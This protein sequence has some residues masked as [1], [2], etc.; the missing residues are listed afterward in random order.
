M[1]P[2]LS[3]YVGATD[4][5]NSVLWKE[6]K[7]SVR[8]GIGVA[9]TVVLDVTGVSELAPDPLDRFTL[10]LPTGEKFVLIPE[11]TPEVGV[12]AIGIYAEDPIVTY[13]YAC[14]DP[15]TALDRLPLPKKGYIESTAGEILIDLIGL[16]DPTLTTTGIED[17]NL[18][19][20]L[21]LTKLNK[22][23]DVVATE[24]L[25]TGNYIV[26]LGAVTG[27][28]VLADYKENFGAS[29]VEVDYTN[30]F[31]AYEPRTTPATDVPFTPTKEP[32]T[33]DNEIINYQ[34]VKGNSDGGPHHSVCEFRELDV[35]VSSF[36][37]AAKPFG[38]DNSQ[39]FSKQFD[40]G[41]VDVDAN[42]DED[43]PEVVPLRFPATVEIADISIDPLTTGEVCAFT[44]KNGVHLLSAVIG[45]TTIGAKVSGTTHN[46]SIPLAPGGAAADDDH[47]YYYDW[48]AQYKLD[49]TLVVTLY[50]YYL[51]A[52]AG[53][54][55]LATVT[56]VNPTTKQIT[57]SYAAGITADD[58]PE[59]VRFF[60]TGDPDDLQFFAKVTA[61]SGTTITL[62]DVPD[63]DSTIDLTTCDL[64]PGEIAKVTTT[65]TTVYS[66]AAHAN[67]FG[68][69]IPQI[70]GSATAARWRHSFGPNVE[71]ILVD[72]AL[73]GVEGRRLRVDAGEASR[74][75]DLVVSASGDTGTCTFTTTFPILQ[76]PVK[77]LLNYDAAKQP[78]AIVQ[79]AASQAIY[80]IRKGDDIESELAYTVDDCEAIG[81]AVVDEFG[82]PSPQGSITRESTLMGSFPLPPRTVAVNL[83]PEYQI[84]TEAVPISEV[85]VDFGG[86]DPMDE[87]GVVIY[88][89][90]LGK[91][92]SVAVVEREL[93]ALKNSRAGGFFIG[94]S[95]GPRAT[96]FTWDDVS[97]CSIAYTG[98][99]SLTL[100]GKPAATT[101]D[102]RDYTTGNLKRKPVKIMG[103]I[104]GLHVVQVEVIYPPDPV[105]D[106]KYTTRYNAKSNTV[107]YRWGRPA[108]ALTYIVQTLKE[109]ADPGDPDDFNPEERIGAETFIVNYDPTAKKIKVTSVGLAFKES[110]PVDLEI[111]LPPLDAPDL[112]EVV[113]IKPNDRVVIRISARPNARATKVRVFTRQDAG[114]VLDPGVDPALWDDFFPKDNDT[115]ELYE[116]D[117]TDEIHR[118]V[119][120]FE[121]TAADDVVWLS[122]TW[123]DIF[124]QEHAYYEP[125]DA[126][127][128][129]MTI[130]SIDAAT[131]FRSPNAGTPATNQAA[132]GTTE[133]DDDETARTEFSGI[134]RYNLGRH[135][136]KIHL[137]IEESTG[138]ADHTEGTWNDHRIFHTPY[139]VTHADA[140]NGYCDIPV[141]QKFKYSKDKRRT[142]RPHRI[143]ID[144]PKIV[145]R[146]G[147]G[148][149]E[150]RVKQKLWY[151]GHDGGSPPALD[152]GTID[153]V[154]DKSLFEFKPGIA[155][156]SN[157]LPVVTGLVVRSK[158]NGFKAKWSP[159][160][161]TK[162]RRYFI[163]LS[164]SP[165]NTTFN[166]TLATEFNAI[167]GTAD[168]LLYRTQGPS[169]IKDVQAHVLDAGHVDHYR[170]HNL[171]QVGSHSIF[172]DER[173]YVAVIV[174]SKSGRYATAFSSVVDS[175]SGVSVSDAPLYAPSNP[176]TAAGTYLIE[177]DVLTTTS[178]ADARVAVRIDANV[179]ATKTFEEA[180][181]TH[182][183]ACFRP[184]G[185][186]DD[187]RLI[188]VG[189]PVTDRTQLY[190]IVS[191]VFPLGERLK[192]VRN[193]TT[194]GGATTK[195]TGAAVNFYVGGS[196]D[197]NLLTGW[198]GGPNPTLERTALDNKHTEVELRFRH[199]TGDAVLVRS[200]RLFQNKDSGGFRR[201]NAPVRLLDEENYFVATA[202]NEEKSVVFVVSTKPSSTYVFKVEIVGV[203]GSIR[204]ITA[205][206]LTNSGDTSAGDAAIDAGDPST[207]AEVAASLTSTATGEP[208][209]LDAT[210]QVTIDADRNG[211]G[212][213][214]VPGTG[215]PIRHVRLTIVDSLGKTIRFGGPTDLSQQSM[216]YATSVKLGGPYTLTEVRYSNGN[217]TDVALTGPGGGFIGGDDTYNFDAGPD[218]SYGSSGTPVLTITAI[219][220]RH[221]L[222]SL[223]YLQP[224]SG[225]PLLVKAVHF[226]LTNGSGVQK[227]GKELILDD[228]VRDAV[229]GRTVTVE[230]VLKCKKRSSV[231]SSAVIVPVG[232]SYRQGGGIGTILTTSPNRL[233]TSSGINTG[234][235]PAQLRDLAAGRG[236][237]IVGGSCCFDAAELGSGTAAEL[238]KNCRTSPGGATRISTT[239]A[240][241]TRWIKG[242]AG[243]TSSIDANAAHCIEL[244][245]GTSGVYWRIRNGI[246]PNSVYWFTF[247][248]AADNAITAS[249]TTI[250][251]YD[252]NASSIFAHTG[253]SID[254]AATY[255]IYAARLV[256]STTTTT[257]D[258]WVGITF[259][260]TTDDIWLSNFCLS[261][262]DEPLLFEPSA[263]E[264]DAQMSSGVSTRD[265]LG[266]GALGHTTRHW[267]DTTLTGSTGFITL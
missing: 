18:V 22:F 102:P 94:N 176:S 24:E 111:N 237:Q 163:A 193:E 125:F 215:G 220:D 81:Q 142:Y 82:F 108:G 7:L 206:G 202:G 246:I 173:Y 66:G 50:E 93:L 249:G 15:L 26:T 225:K 20:A 214:A 182:A 74:S 148:A 62:D 71:A 85:S 254:I 110:A 265:F 112:L 21:D 259:S 39:L 209:A 250:G 170:F 168:V 253:V 183:Y 264:A 73:Y 122:A 70:S 227:H 45:T 186:G 189:G 136:E 4:W 137:W 132:G 143:V 89:I 133:D 86:Y 17:G 201:V 68:K 104:G 13:S 174:Q 252:G 98:G 233:A 239:L 178:S 46:V 95:G 113:K 216:T 267:E 76:G 16:L 184:Y 205:S 162:V 23:S 38:V 171:D 44:G 55:P 47:Q 120:H 153:G 59:D 109:K 135:N 217:A 129:P 210:V 64:A 191:G 128:P 151:V 145:E 31:S 208:T 244:S 245:P 247:A 138:T 119:I 146:I 261:I 57:V 251:I 121:D 221:V 213:F 87:E 181:A 149:E 167:N 257:P 134:F 101:F 238:G 58:I 72:D 37:L 155:G 211:T 207:F 240:S 223:T 60:T 256:P 212:T 100:A 156:L 203:D 42:D 147:P 65:S 29:G 53:N 157:N 229:L 241:N 152:P 169:E 79:D 103:S 54:T 41:V 2:T 34:V 141:T 114:T 232:S 105:N 224:A 28:D 11:G 30:L 69:P 126:T 56:A 185:D 1:P 63:A 196:V 27:L 139:E 195:S 107:T 5:T 127:R 78:E 198:S 96:G 222:A 158:D 218:G 188:K 150:D 140:A 235:D 166:T 192:W 199:P 97:V 230:K 48:V 154:F 8:D 35:T 219:D 236:N 118:R 124:G 84:G 9:A 131:F 36:Q 10:T 179:G 177:N 228:A 164:R 231:S 194:S 172:A 255:K 187:T 67:R 248:I 266:L 115:V 197:L 258:A 19:P 49:D 165:F 106:E 243:N 204:T 200:V 83:P 263:Q 32:L 160:N 190:T 40:L 175:L 12:Y 180:G 25:S 159:L 91:L 14:I 123:V 90:T 161:T 80:G 77:I 144:G 75:T 260:G 52:V 51:N 116:F 33:P 242:G 92:D 117:A 262:G 61:K 3:L 226:R 130:G 99:G 6:F 43:L 234:N 88:S